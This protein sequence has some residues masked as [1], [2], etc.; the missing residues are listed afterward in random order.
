MG[1]TSYI[2]LFLFLPVTTLIW[3]PVSRIKNT[4]A[5]NLYLI[6]ISFVFYFWAGA[7]SFFSFLLMIIATYLFGQLIQAYRTK[8]AHF[9]AIAVT[10]F[11]GFLLSS[12]YLT[13]LLT[14][15]K[16]SN[17]VWGKSLVSMLI[18]PLGI[19]FVTFEAVSYFVDI[20]RGDAKPGSLLDVALFLSLYPKLISG[21]IILWK[22]FT[23][24]TRNHPVQPDLIHSGLRKIAFG[25]AKK[26]LL[27]DSMGAIIASINTSMA[28]GIDT[29]TYWLRALLYMFQLYY[30]FS[31]YSD[32][33]IGLMQLFGFTVKDNFK[34]PYSSCSVSEFWR[35][36]HISLGTWF[37]EYVYFPLG[38]SRKGN[39]YLN[40]FIVFLLTG[41]WHG[42]TN[43]FLVWGILH[44][45]IVVFE[46]WISNTAFY[47]KTPSVIKWFFTMLFVGFTWILFMSPSLPSAFDALK[48]MLLPRLNAGYNWS[49]TYF[50]TLKTLLLLVIGGLLS[51]LGRFDKL[52]SSVRR[53]STESLA[54]II[55]TD[56]LCLALM[57]LSILFVV[58][59]SYS[60]FLYFQF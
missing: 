51:I 25:Y 11:V 50:L 22:D 40:L 12:K 26:V 16:A 58:N 47:K 37:R 19:S 39:V 45:L 13:P 1:F 21:P 5:H 57:A 52:S 20:Y 27:A 60:P 36:W 33:A 56:I 28:S 32:I 24:Q 3:F 9:L 4:N 41:I 14:L 38:G 55:V 34:Y 17:T 53:F 46:R 10:L 23:S 35:R 54:G 48:A 6:L 18:V 15:L 59:S 30:D 2:F 8:G 29:K 49:F 42:S 43:T 44:G 31:G 7:E